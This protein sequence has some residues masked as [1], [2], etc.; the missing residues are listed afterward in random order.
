MGAYFPVITPA[1][2]GSQQRFF[3]IF[4]NSVARGM[5][6]LGSVYDPSVCMRRGILHE[7]PKAFR[8][9]GDRRSLDG[10]T[11]VANMPARLAGCGIKIFLVISCR[12][13]VVDTAWPLFYTLLHVLRSHLS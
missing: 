11:E 8:A 12:P 10:S 1:C 13:R 5:G 3:F 4:G 9:R 2:L 7:N 6:D